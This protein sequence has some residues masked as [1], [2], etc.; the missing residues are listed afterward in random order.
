MRYVMIAFLCMIAFMI[1][2]SAIPPAKKFVTR[3]YVPEY[4]LSCLYYWVSD[5]E[6][7]KTCP[8]DPDYPPNPI[9]IDLGN[10]SGSSIGGLIN[11]IDYQEL[12]KKSCSMWR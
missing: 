7:K 11:E 6:S 10:P 12:L 4:V 2:C 1:S 5:N 9:V 8:G 3:T